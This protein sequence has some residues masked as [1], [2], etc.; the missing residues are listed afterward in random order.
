MGTGPQLARSHIG[1]WSGI[2]FRA[3]NEIGERIGRQVAKWPNT[4]YF[5]P[6]RAHERKLC[7][8]GARRPLPA[9]P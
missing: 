3:A 8:W 9:S 5:K 6:V 1:V 7:V 2:H 4:R